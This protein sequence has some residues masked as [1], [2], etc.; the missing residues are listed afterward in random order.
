[1]DKTLRE[2]K[3]DALDAR[4]AD[5]GVEDAVDLANT[6]CAAADSC[7]A[8]VQHLRRQTVPR[9]EKAE[10][11]FLEALDREEEDATDEDA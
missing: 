10:Q 9:R 5:V 7:L 4:A 1:M 3:Q 8:Q 2:L 6:E 11:L